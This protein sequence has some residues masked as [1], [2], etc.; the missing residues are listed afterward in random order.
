MTNIA[1]RLELGL[2]FVH[3]W[4]PRA[5]TIAFLYQNVNSEFVFTI[6]NIIGRLNDE[7][8]SVTERTKPRDELSPK[9]ERRA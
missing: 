5:G 4:I 1:P 6:G 9:H 7:P 2:R 3:T 8:A